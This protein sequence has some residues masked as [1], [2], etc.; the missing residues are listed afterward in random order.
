MAQDRILF[1]AGAKVEVIAGKGSPIP[2]EN[3]LALYIQELR[4]D[5]RTFL[6]K[7]LGPNREGVVE[8]TISGQEIGRAHV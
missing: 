4:V 1:N 5:P 7:D 6:S 8:M 2:K 3:L